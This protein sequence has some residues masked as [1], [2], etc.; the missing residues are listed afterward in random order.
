[1]NPGRRMYRK[2]IL[3]GLCA[4]TLAL[5]SNYLRGAILPAFNPS[6]SDF[7][8]LYASSW[9][10]LHGQ[11]P[12]DSSLA[13]AARQGIVG[14]RDQI[15]LVNV[16]TALV[17]ASP[18]AVLPWGWANFAFLLL[19]TGGLVVTTRFILRS[20]GDERSDV[21]VGFL[22]VFLLSF[23]PLRIAFQWGNIVLLVFPLAVLAIG[24][25]QRT[26]D[27]QAGLLL[28]IVVCLKPQI[29]LW[30]ALYYLIRG[31][32]RLVSMSVAVG[33]AITAVFFL[34]PIRLQLLIESYRSNL[35]HW[36]GPG[37]PYGFTEGSVPSLLL[38]TQ[39]I[40]YQVTHSVTASSY[41]AQILFLSGAAAWFIAVWRG[42][43]RIPAPL[44]IAS[45]WSLSFLSFYH[46]IP[47]ASVL[48][49]SLYGALPLRSWTRKQQLTYALLFL[50]ML[51]ERSIFV[52]LHHHLNRSVTQSWWW[53][54][55]LA[56]HFAWLLVGLSFALIMQMYEIQGRGADARISQ[57]NA[58]TGN[59]P[60]CPMAL[61]A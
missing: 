1:M 19:G 31:R 59:C 22:V 47:D 2:A 13:T 5:A 52:F 53:D 27:W 36:F 30:P 50:I 9:V 49:L 58:E 35:Q 11:N 48:T 37:G 51:P 28:G 32:F 40:L 45:L 61:T 17:L 12:Y 7:S 4:V 8:E 44:A 34:H 43:N 23:S 24:L 29:G 14:G 26:Q 16:P 10:W 41:L 46:S 21:A 55:F 39:G 6:S 60:Q 56:R 57:F 42:G 18:F 15:F 38:R 3:L 25:A 20:T 54:L 33:A